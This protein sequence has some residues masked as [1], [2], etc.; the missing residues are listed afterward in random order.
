M[1][2]TF[3]GIQLPVPVGQ[4]AGDPAM[5]Y[6]GNYLAAFLNAKLATAWAAVAPTLVPV[7]KVFLHNPIDGEFNEADLPALFLYRTEI[8]GE[9]WADEW[10]VQKSTL[11]AQWVF[12]NAISYEQ[13]RRAPFV[14]AVAKGLHVAIEYGRDPSYVI[15]GDT[16][17]IAGTKGSFVFGERYMNTVSVDFKSARSAQ[18]AIRMADGSPSRTYA[19][20]EARI[21]LVEVAEDD[22]TRFAEHSTLGVSTE[23]EEGTQTATLILD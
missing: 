10:N 4:P 19:S 13:A 9:V 17:A 2:D 18:L 5:G 16:E 6:L 8:Q 21:A 1:A 7:R 12:P 11:V 15:P 23:T 3:G 20:I 22:V 14:N